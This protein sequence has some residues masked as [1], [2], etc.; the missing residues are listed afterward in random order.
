LRSETALQSVTDSQTPLRLTIFVQPMNLELSKPT[1]VVT[2]NIERQS[3]MGSNPATGTGSKPAT[4][5]FTETSVPSGIVDEESMTNL[6]NQATKES[7]L[8][9]FSWSEGQAPD[10]CLQ[11]FMPSP[12]MWDT[13]TEDDD[14]EVHMTPACHA[15]LPFSKW[16]GTVH[17]RFDVVA[18]ERHRGIF[19]IMWDPI[20]MSTDALG[21]FNELPSMICDISE[22]RSFEFA[23]PWGHYK[24]WLDG[25]DGDWTVPFSGSPFQALRQ[26]SNGVLNLVVVNPLN[27]QADSLKPVT[28]FAHCKMLKD[29]EVVDPL[30]RP[31]LRIKEKNTNENTD[32]DQNVPIDLDPNPQEPTEPPEPPEPVAPGPEP[33][34]NIGTYTWSRF[35]M[36]YAPVGYGKVWSNSVGGIPIT[37]GESMTVRTEG[38][39]YWYRIFGTGGSTI[40]TPYT[41][42]DSN[43]YS[44][45]KDFVGQD[46]EVA[47]NSGTTNGPVKTFVPTNGELKTWNFT[48]LT[49]LWPK[50]A[51]N[52]SIYYPDNRTDDNGIQSALL[53]DGLTVF[54]E[55][56]VP[57]AGYTIVFKDG[58]ATAGSSVTNTTGQ[59]RKYQVAYASEVV[60]SPGTRLVFIGYWS[61][62]SARTPLQPLRANPLLDSPPTKPRLRFLSQRIPRIRM[63]SNPRPPR[64]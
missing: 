58:T 64:L 54:T 6:V 14:V 57:G 4:L 3:W 20:G 48:G 1:S 34:W 43:G 5:G 40:P 21:K 32:D 52:W 55:F 51:N 26:F 9:T 22:T 44:V 29:F 12:Y 36:P 47:L 7:F 35:Q 27:S 10:T 39:R 37:S 16:R 28:I 33:N 53:P 2:G 19:R 18:S 38:D 41:L 63:K 24:N 13:H 62:F 59:Y 8:T 30:P 17:F 23:V 49:C 45:T 11:S 61:Q 15:A 56:S 60:F 50:D 31:M 25:H 46:L 42:T